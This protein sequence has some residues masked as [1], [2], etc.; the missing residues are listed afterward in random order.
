MKYVFA[1]LFLFPIYSRADVVVQNS[2][3]VNTVWSPE[4]GV[5][6]LD[7]QISVATGTT[8]TLLPG[9]VV[10]LKFNSGIFVDGRIVADSLGTSTPIVFTSYDDDEYGGDTNQNATSTLPNDRNWLGITFNPGSDSHFNNVV[11]KYSGQ[12]TIGVSNYSGLSVNSA[13]LAIRNSFIS[14]NG[15]H[16]IVNIQGE[17][18]VSNSVIE[19]NIFG[20]YAE[21]GTTHLENNVIRNNTV[22]GVHAGIYGELNL[23]NNQFMNNQSTAQIGAG[24]MFTHTGNSSLDRSYRGFNTLGVPLD[25]QIIGGSDLPIIISGGLMSIATGTTVSIRPGT[26]IK[27]DNNSS[28][29]VSGNLNINGEKNN[30]VVFTSIKD[31]SVMGDTNADGS[32]TSPSANDLQGIVF[33]KGSYSNISNTIFKHSLRGII[34]NGGYINIVD[35]VFATSTHLAIHVYDGNLNIT[36]SQF[37]S[38]GGIINYGSNILN[39]ESNWWGSNTGPHD[40]STS[41]P[42]GIGSSVNINVLYSS[43]L[44]R[45][46]VL[47]N[48]VIIIPGIMGSYLLKDDGSDDEVWMNLT[49]MVFSKNDEYLN[50]LALTSDESDSIN[51]PIKVGDIIRSTG[52]PLY[53]RHLFDYLISEIENSGYLE[54]FDLFVFPYDWRFDI[55]EVSVK[56]SEK[57]NEIINATGS[58]E[59]DL[60]AHSMGGLVV[61]KY[62]SVNANNSIGKFIDIGTPHFGSPKSFQTLMYGET[63]IPILSEE[64][65]SKITDS[66]PSVYQLLPSENYFDSLNTDYSYY[67][68]D[69]VGGNKRLNFSDTKQY[70]KDQGRNSSLIDKS[71]DL[72]EEIDNLSPAD[73]GVE[74]YNIVGCGTPT[75]GKI[76]VLSK[77]KDNYDYAI[78][79]INGDGTVPLRSAEAMLANETYYVNEAQHATMPS[80]SGVKE[81]VISI[82][83]NENSFDKTNYSNILDTSDSC[84]IPDGK[85]VS[86]HSPITLRIKDQYDN[87][88]GPNENDDIENNI[89]GLVYE[90]IEDT[91]FVY[92]PDGINYTVY[93]EATGSG[94]FDIRVET[95]ENGEVAKTDLYNDIQLTENTRV[96][97]N[98]NS[99]SVEK[100]YIDSDGNGVADLEKEISAS[101]IGFLEPESQTRSQIEDTKVSNPEPQSRQQNIE[102]YSTKINYFVDNKL[103]SSTISLNVVEVK[104]AKQKVAGTGIKKVVIYGNSNLALVNESVLDLIKNWFRDLI[105]WFKSKL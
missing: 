76:Y 72:H 43:W 63:G 53:T 56:L 16:G 98:V 12:S 62:L 11:F 28:F 94:Y 33:S 29:D 69:G 67:V 103:S 31:D 89:E 54:G 52:V 14:T 71:D 47:P 84:S 32:L 60:V 70:L 64:I 85:L 82:L 105:E 80:S 93:G 74:T 9:T 88:A 68:F 77:E 36:N 49:K 100:V 73:Y 40:V 23:V 90:V 15:R 26:V 81:L 59:V 97:F 3:D 27:F 39:A 57:I 104:K 38:Q 13:K 21:S 86:F 99:G 65:I 20:V 41:S 61:K 51:N 79:M 2:I 34:N 83:K 101:M 42:S 78:Q 102:E 7:G 55:E 4:Y 8:L 17:V 37:L 58:S 30:D 35:S 95:I 44:R 92:L 1:L 46:P 87:Y 22:E 75:L 6:I 5:Y 91:K 24:V 50:Y 96:Q 19:N 45:D 66:M 18:S 10:K 25:G 48:P